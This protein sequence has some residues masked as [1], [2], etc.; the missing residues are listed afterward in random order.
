MKDEVYPL[1]AC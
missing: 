1:E